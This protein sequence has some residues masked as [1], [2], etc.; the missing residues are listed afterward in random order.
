M[1]DGKILKFW[2]DSV[3]L[4][5]SLNVRIVSYTNAGFVLYD[6]AETLLRSDNVDRVYYFLLGRKSI[7]KD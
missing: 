2:D 5:K 3:D 7:N 1:N 6:G 4:A